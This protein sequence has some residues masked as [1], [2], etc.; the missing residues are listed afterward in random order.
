M[1]IRITLVL[2]VIGWLGLDCAGALLNTG[3]SMDDVVR[4]AL[5]VSLSAA[6]SVLAVAALTRIRF[7][8]PDA[9]L[10]SN[11]WIAGLVAASA[12]CASQIGRAHV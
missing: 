2:F 10:C 11:G 9:S 7:G 12:G 5:T 3:A 1:N 4:V 8:K 6:A